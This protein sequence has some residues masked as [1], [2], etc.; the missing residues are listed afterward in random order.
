MLHKSEESISVSETCTR[1]SQLIGKRRCTRSG[2]FKRNKSLTVNRSNG[3][4]YSLSHLD[5]IS[6]PYLKMAS[7]GDWSEICDGR[8]IWAVVTKPRCRNRYG[9]VGHDITGLW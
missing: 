3:D 1:L 5:F 6:V 8:Y 2:V 9:S 7:E 4:F